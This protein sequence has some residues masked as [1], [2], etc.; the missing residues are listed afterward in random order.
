[1]QTTSI[2]FAAR[3]GFSVQD[4]KN[5]ETNQLDTHSQQMYHN[6]LA[7]FHS[8]SMQF[9]LLNTDN[10]L[11]IKGGRTVLS[12]RKTNR[13][14]DS[15]YFQVQYQGQVPLPLGSGQYGYAD[16][17]PF[18]GKKPQDKQI[19][20]IDA[21]CRRT[22]DDMVTSDRFIKQYHRENKPKQP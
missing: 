14:Y 5:P 16:P 4:Y 10:D 21:A 13:L 19:Q 6:A 1:M 11:V 18:R 12:N 22:L 20:T 9:I 15:G 17:A 3:L 2:K 8:P 7:A